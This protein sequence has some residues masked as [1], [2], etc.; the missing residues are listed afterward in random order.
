MA[1]KTFPDPEELVQRIR[2]MTEEIPGF[3]H[4]TLAK[5]RSLVASVKVTPEFLGIIMS[6]LSASAPLRAAFDEDPEAI[7]WAAEFHAH[8][9]SVMDEAASFERGMRTTAAI[10]T[11]KGGTMALQAYHI[12]QQLIRDPANSELIPFVQEMK[13]LQKRGKRRK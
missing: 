3:E 12:A 2:A 7:R 1:G 5:A 13:R 8:Y 9:S 10:W 4:L 6:A 11:N